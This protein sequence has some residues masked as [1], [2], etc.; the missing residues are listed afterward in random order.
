MLD[1]HIRKEF[2]QSDWSENNQLAFEFLKR[3]FLKNKNVL[4]GFYYPVLKPEDYGIDVCIYKSERAYRE[5][6]LPIAYIE[7]EIKTEAACEWK[8]GRYPF[9]DIHFLYRKAHL[10]HQNA[11][12]FWVCYNKKGTDCAVLPIEAVSAYPL[13]QNSSK[14][15]DLV[16]VI[17]REACQFGCETLVK[18]ID[19]YFMSQ[20]GL[21]E[22]AF[23]QAPDLYIGIVNH[24]YQARHRY[25]ET[26][27]I[28]EELLDKSRKNEKMIGVKVFL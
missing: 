6:Y 15:E 9:S 28:Q 25:K 3:D 19:E 20:V 1:Q 27:N 21:G 16:Y 2:S 12:P 18:S 17:P 23:I 14:H 4:G 24:A 7:L 22:K 13:C 26:H 10:L 5:N 11:I 8:A